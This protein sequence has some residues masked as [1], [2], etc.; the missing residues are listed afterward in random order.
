M[1][2]LYVLASAFGDRMVGL[3]QWLFRCTHH[4]TTFPMTLPVNGSIPETYV[5]CLGCGRH[6]AYNW[7]TMHRARQST[8]PA[9]GS[10]LGAVSRTVSRTSMRRPAL[11]GFLASAA[12]DA[13]PAA[14]DEIVTAMGAV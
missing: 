6:F 9:A 7:S 3:V 10:Q 14:K 12:M 11:N 5:A 2:Q 1:E 13:A 4:R 8:A